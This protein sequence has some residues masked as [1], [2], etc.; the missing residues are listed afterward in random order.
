MSGTAEVIIIVIK[1][2][3]EKSGRC[4]HIVQATCLLFSVRA[5]LMVNGLQMDAG[6]TQYIE[7][8]CVHL[9]AGLLLMQ[10]LC[11]AHF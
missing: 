8:R 3:L 11:M 2:V 4:H 9:F 1:F 10:A 7:S 5:M 6:W